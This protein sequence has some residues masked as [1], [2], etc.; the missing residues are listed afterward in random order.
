MVTGQFVVQLVKAR[1]L[2]LILVLQRPWL[3]E[4]GL[5]F[6]KLLMQAHKALF[7][8]SDKLS[9]VIHSVVNALN[10]D[11]FA[12]TQLHHALSITMNTDTHLVHER[13]FQIQRKAAVR[14]DRTSI[15]V[16]QFAVHVLRNLLA[17]SSDHGQQCF[18]GLVLGIVSFPVQFDTESIA[19]GLRVI[20]VQRCLI[21]FQRRNHVFFLNNAVRQVHIYIVLQLIL[22][23]VVCSAQDG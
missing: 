12:V 11:G 20:C 15:L 17:F 19:L 4:V 22:V 21:S 10:T 8:V 7:V 1:D 2:L 18:T 23:I 16:S 14:A 9:D 3:A 13:T 6:I 5:G